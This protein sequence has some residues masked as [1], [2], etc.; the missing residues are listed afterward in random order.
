MGSLA[1][2][3]FVAMALGA[4]LH[5]FGDRLS[6]ATLIVVLTLGLMLAG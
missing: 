3:L 5:A 1:A 2:E 6:L 4:S